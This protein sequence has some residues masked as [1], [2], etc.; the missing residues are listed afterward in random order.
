MEDHSA[1]GG[2][3]LCSAAFSDILSYP[4]HNLESS[5]V[6]WRDRTKPMPELPEVETV[7]RG[8]APVMEGATIK[9]MIKRRPNLR[10]PMPDD[11]ETALNGRQ[12]T[13]LARVAKYI[14]IHFDSGP[15]LLLHLGMSGR[16]A[17]LPPNEAAT[18]PRGP[19]DHVEFHLTSGW[20]VILTDPRRFGLLVFTDR[21]DPKSH[22]LLNHLAPDPLSNGFSEAMLSQALKPKKTPIKSALLDQTIVAGLGNIYVCE[23]L[24]RAG[25]SPRR[26]AHTV[27]GKRAARL[28]PHIR[29][30]L[31]EAIDAGGSTL[32][33]HRQADG[34]LGYFQHRFAVY[35]REG[36]PCPNSDC[37]STIKRIV[38]S[39]RSSF[40][41]SQCQR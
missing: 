5:R 1:P 38:Q 17:I 22:K 10:F 39:G 18:H 31:R 6:P 34:T 7:K 12:I 33:D 11:L 30:V 14:L 8:L 36:A 35:D 24:F 25:I 9:S 16:V 20:Q 41:C 4:V 40:F 29:D 37:D 28:V 19:H 32:R 21:D 2:F 26:S 27:A 23:A 15:A 3:G 13:G